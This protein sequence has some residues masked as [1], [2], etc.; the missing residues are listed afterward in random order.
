MM[1]ETSPPES[2]LVPNRTLQRMYAGM[3]ESRMLEEKLCKRDGKAARPHVHGQE[4][5][6]AGALF[7]LAPEDFTSD[8]YGSVTAAYLRGEPLDTLVHH[9]PGSVSSLAGLLPESSETRD[10]LQQAVGAA[11]ALK[12]LKL[13]HVVVF[14]TGADEVKPTAWLPHLHRAAQLELAMLFVLLPEVTGKTDL[15]VKLAASSGFSERATAAGVPGIPVDASDAIALYRVAQE[16]LTRARA[17]GGPALME[18]IP[19]V[20]EGKKPKKK[21]PLP[22]PVNALGDIL[23]RRK[24]CDQAALDGIAAAFQARLKSI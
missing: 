13:N 6:R 21:A 14:F 22:D 16:S 15:K 5:C 19:F 9:R 17:G 20:L 2:P 18:C 4:A 7:D 11:I 12:R 23:L 10:R 8:L 3:V 24:L 1:Q